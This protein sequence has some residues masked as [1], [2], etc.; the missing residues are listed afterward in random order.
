MWKEPAFLSALLLW[1]KTSIRRKSASISIFLPAK[2][3]VLGCPAW[4]SSLPAVAIKQNMPPTPVTGV[5]AL[6][7]QQ[8]EN[9]CC[10]ALQL[11]PFPSVP[12]TCNWNHTVRSARPWVEAPWAAGVGS[13]PQRGHGLVLNTLLGGMSLL[14]C[15]ARLK[16][17]EGRE[18]EGQ[19]VCSDF[20]KAGSAAAGPPSSFNW[21]KKLFLSRQCGWALTFR[22]RLCQRGWWVAGAGSGPTAQQLKVPLSNREMLCWGFNS[23]FSKS[24]LENKYSVSKWGK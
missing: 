15:S 14:H 18:G 13:L 3:S 12:F 19:R 16:G 7:F 20:C 21:C 5:A 4:L 10:P 11:A 23:S 24:W 9:F 22:S 8:G 6:G 17:W 1:S 2:L